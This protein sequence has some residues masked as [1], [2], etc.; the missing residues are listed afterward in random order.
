MG[1][2]S[3]CERLTGYVRPIWL[4]LIPAKETVVHGVRRRGEIM[5]DHLSIPLAIREF[6][7]PLLQFKKVGGTVPFGDS[8]DAVI[9]GLINGFGK[10]VRRYL[11][12]LLIAD[13][14]ADR[15]SDGA[16]DIKRKRRYKTWSQVQKYRFRR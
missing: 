1:V 10:T 16:M 6:F 9:G 3:N 8:P 12:F 2:V 14:I 5:T 4:L 13:N 15:Q 7:H 11:P